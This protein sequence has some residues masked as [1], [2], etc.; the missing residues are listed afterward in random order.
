LIIVTRMVSLIGNVREKR[1]RVLCSIS[2]TRR[3]LRGD[4][5]AICAAQ[6]AGDCQKPF[7]I[8]D[9]HGYPDKSG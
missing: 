4:S 3:P 9:A 5:P 8:R 1:K 6:I 7:S 2:P